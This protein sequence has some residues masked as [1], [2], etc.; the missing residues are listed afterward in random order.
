MF[1]QMFC[2]GAGLLGLHSR[3]MTSEAQGFPIE[4]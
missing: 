1:A 4:H 2:S 3:F